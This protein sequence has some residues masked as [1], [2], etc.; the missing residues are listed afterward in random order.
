MKR[1]L[2]SILIYGMCLS[3]AV[4]AI[5][6]EPET[7]T[8]TNKAIRVTTALNHLTVLEFQE[9]VT[10]VAAGG[11]DFQIERQENK[12]F[13]KPL[14]SGVST[15]L[16]V[17]TASRRFNYELEPAGEVKDMNFAIDNSFT[18]PKP[19]VDPQAQPD[20]LADM[21]L[22]RAFLGAEPIDNTRISS[23]K[24]SVAV[25]IEHVFRTKNSLYVHYSIENHGKTPYH[26]AAPSAYQLEV[27][28]SSIS[29]PVLEHRQLDAQ[30][31]RKLGDLKELAL[32]I[33]HAETKPEDLSPGESA[34]G[35]VAI[36][37]DLDSP[38]VLQLVFD[39]NIKA[40][41]VL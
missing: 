19:A 24:N 5:S 40:I 15:N 30:T 4:T 39:A 29:L 41:L 27:N 17:W 34:N 25:R 6:Q 28:T 18:A 20:Q 38:V 10:L 8:K 2:P 11:T 37:R 14:K 3:C 16:F 31:V 12:V 1:L 33:G 32:P 21:M 36:R 22:T 7:T 9:P 23:A 26:V 13:V 35:V